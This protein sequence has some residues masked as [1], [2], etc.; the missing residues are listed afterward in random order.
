MS[1]VG[2]LKTKQ[3]GAVVSLPFLPALIGMLRFEH[4]NLIFPGLGKPERMTCTHYY[5]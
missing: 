5:T 2:F 1:Q 3:E 4:P